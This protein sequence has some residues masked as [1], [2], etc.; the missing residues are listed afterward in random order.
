M[1][2]TCLHRCM[3][4]LLIQN[5]FF[6][7]PSPFLGLYWRKKFLVSFYGNW[8]MR[9]FTSQWGFTIGTVYWLG[10]RH[11]WSPGHRCQVSSRNTLLVS[12]GSQG[13]LPLMNSTDTKKRKVQCLM[14]YLFFKNNLR[15]RMQGMSAVNLKNIKAW[16]CSNIKNIVVFSRVLHDSTPRFVRPTDLILT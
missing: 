11:S 12:E 10:I 9:V 15:T 1:Y 16:N 3:V 14:Q 8:V 2:D 6:A 13:P 7:L 5:I 4:D